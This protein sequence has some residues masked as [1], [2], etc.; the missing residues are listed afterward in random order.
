MHGFIHG[1]FF[2]TSDVAGS[3]LD[4]FMDKTTVMIAI[5]T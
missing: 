2:Y 5:F 3:T 4:F 1:L